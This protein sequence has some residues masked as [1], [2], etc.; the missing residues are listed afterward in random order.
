[1]D[2]DTD[3]D[4]AFLRFGLELLTEQVVKTIIIDKCQYQWDIIV[5]TLHFEPSLARWR[6][7]LRQV[8]GKMSCRGSRTAVA[9]REYVIVVLPGMKKEFNG[10]INTTHRN[11]PA[12]TARFL[13]IVLNET[14]VIHLAPSRIHQDFNALQIEPEPFPSQTLPQHSLNNIVLV[15]VFAVEHQGPTATSTDMLPTSRAILSSEL[16]G[17]DDT[18][19]RHILKTE[20]S[21]LFC[22]SQQRHTNPHTA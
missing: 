8:T 20:N 9:A 17:F 15:T 14:P 10:T 2:T 3:K 1:M 16:I 22:Q 18:S 7:R 12:H 11:Q 4:I 21:A 5:Q 13:K 19:V 6:N